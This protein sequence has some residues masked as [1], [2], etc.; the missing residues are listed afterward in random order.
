MVLQKA[1]HKWINNAQL[2]NDVTVF[3]HLAKRSFFPIELVKQLD[4]SQGEL[5]DVS[6]SMIEIYK[7]MQQGIYKHKERHSLGFAEANTFF[8][9]WIDGSIRILS[10]RYSE[11]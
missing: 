2:D 6:F 11:T 7:L 4:L 10:N 3:C 1:F 5:E 9:K 8:V